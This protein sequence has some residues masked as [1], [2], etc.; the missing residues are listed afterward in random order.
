[1]GARRLGPSRP[2]LSLWHLQVQIKAKCASNS[3]RCLLIAGGRVCPPRL[4]VLVVHTK[5]CQDFHPPAQALLKGQLWPHFTQDSRCS[6]AQWPPPPLARNS[7]PTGSEVQSLSL[8][9]PEHGGFPA[10]PRR[11]ATGTVHAPQVVA[12]PAVLPQSTPPQPQ[13]LFQPP[14]HLDMMPRPCLPC[15]PSVLSPR[16]PDSYMSDHPH[17]PAPALGSWPQG[18]RAKS[19]FT[20]RLALHCTLPCFAVC[21]R[22]GSWDSMG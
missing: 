12:S 3:A 16:S 19:P 1:M 13:C 6:P 10:V 5:P 17:S 7:S 22:Q 15:P 14:L 18:L 21:A 8:P 20:G 11:A 2:S 9:A 4:L